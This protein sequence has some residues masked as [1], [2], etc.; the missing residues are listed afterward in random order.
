[1]AELTLFQKIAERRIPAEIVYEDA[2][3]FAIRDIHPQAPTHLLIIPRKPIAGLTEVEETDAPLV[4]HL[5]VV[6]ARLAREEGL[7]GGY[8][9][10]FNS[11]K[12]AGQSVDHLHLHLLGGRAL[13]WP[14][15]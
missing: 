8:R 1:M 10:V 15:G 12:D 4:G 3:C 13:Q 5:L 2:Q 11:G 9:T 7:E 6:A 14:P